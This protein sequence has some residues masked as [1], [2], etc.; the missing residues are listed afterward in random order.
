[1]QILF[2]KT[3]SGKQPRKHESRNIIFAL[4]VENMYCVQLLLSNVGLITF[5]YV[6]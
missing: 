1:M 6:K 4:P 3:L 5:Y 2:K